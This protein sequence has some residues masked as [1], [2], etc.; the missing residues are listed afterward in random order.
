MFKGWA[1]LPAAQCLFGKTKVAL[2]EIP[3]EWNEGTV[4]VCRKPNGQLHFVAGA[5]GSYSEIGKFVEA[6]HDQTGSQFPG[7]WE[8]INEV[9]YK[10]VD[11]QV[12]FS[13]KIPF[14]E[15]LNVG[16]KAAL[17]VFK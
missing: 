5:S 12:Q 13:P 7:R 2:S 15:T 1:I 10:T 9:A 3:R 4:V 16:T 6:Y 14:G 17:A 8:V 11:G